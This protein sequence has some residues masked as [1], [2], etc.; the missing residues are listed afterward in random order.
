MSKTVDRWAE[1][2]RVVAEQPSRSIAQIA[3]D[4]GVNPETVTRAAQHFG[5]QR[6]RKWGDKLITSET[7]LHVGD[8]V[9]QHSTHRQAEIVGLVYH[10][11][12]TVSYRCRPTSEF[13][14][15]KTRFIHERTLRVNYVRIKTTERRLP[16]ERFLQWTFGLSNSSPGPSRPSASLETTLK[17]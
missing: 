2:A 3:Q 11:D 10:E 12:L 9:M 8:L 4:F 1:I 7:W 16:D 6:Y 13:R 14:K 17:S 15:G 5:V